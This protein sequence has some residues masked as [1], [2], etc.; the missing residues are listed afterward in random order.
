MPPRLLNDTSSIWLNRSTSIVPALKATFLAIAM[1]VSPLVPT[2]LST[3]AVSSALPE[4][5]AW[6]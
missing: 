5:L 1:A 4:S 3:D 2:I 6:V